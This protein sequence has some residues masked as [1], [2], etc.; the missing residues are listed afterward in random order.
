MTMGKRKPRYVH[1]GTT[2]GLE[3]FLPGVKIHVLGPPTL[4]E[5]PDIASYAKKSDDYWLRRRQI[6]L[7]DGRSGR[8]GV[9]DGS[10]FPRARRRSKGRCPAHMTW[11][12]ARLQRAYADELL[13][14]VTELDGVLNNTSIILLFEVA[15]QKLLFPGDAQLENWTFALTH[16]ANLLKGVTVYKVGH[17][18]SL[19]A[20]PKTLW[21]ILTEGNTAVAT[22]KFKTLMSTK[23]G[24]HGGEHGNPTEVPRGPLVDE[25]RDKSTLT[26]TLDRDDFGKPRVVQT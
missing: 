25:L 4:D 13:G 5:A 23:A 14:I 9:A 1:A 21:R 2:S 26:T 6:A 15:G 11:F 3:T 7:A 10:L 18:G 22:A 8:G 17:H 20:T 19:N 12:I 16:Y 24:A